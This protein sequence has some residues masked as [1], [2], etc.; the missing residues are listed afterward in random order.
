L[1]DAL[2][3]DL[4]KVKKKNFLNEIDLKNK[5][6]SKASNEAWIN[7]LTRNQS[8]I[9]E[10]FCGQYKSTISCL[11]CKIISIKY[12][13]FYILSLPIPDLEYVELKIVFINYNLA[14]G[15]FMFNI[16]IEQDAKV[17]NLRRKISKSFKIPLF[18]F[19]LCSIINNRIDR[20]FNSNIPVVKLTSTICCFQID[21]SLFNS[22]SNR[23]KILD[24]VEPSLELELNF[25]VEENITRNQ[26]SFRD[27][28]IRCDP[29]NTYYSNLDSTFTKLSDVQHNVGKSSENSNKSDIN[30][31]NNLNVDLKVFCDDNYGL[32]NDFIKVV[33]YLRAIKK[34]NIIVSKQ[35]LTFARLIYLNKNW[36]LSYIHRYIFSFLK[37]FIQD[38]QKYSGLKYI[39]DDEGFDKVYSRPDKILYTQV[40]EGSIPYVIK[41]INNNANH[42]KPCFMCKDMNCNNCLLMYN[43]NIQLLSLLQKYPIINE[44]TV[45]N[46]YMYMD[47]LQRKFCLGKKDFEIEIVFEKFFLKKDKFFSQAKTSKTVNSSFLSPQNYSLSVYDCL[48]RFIQIEDLESEN[49]WLCTNCKSLEKAK[50]NIEISKN[51]LILILQLKR[52]KNNHKVK[53]TIDFPLNNL[54]L[55]YF[56]G[57]NSK[58]DIS[59]KYDL[60]G[61]C[62]HYGSLN[63]GHYYAFCKNSLNG[64]WYKYDDAEVTEI[65][66]KDVVSPYSYVL[67]YRRKDLLNGEYDIEKL[68]N[69]PFVD[70]ENLLKNN[71]FEE[72]RTNETNNETLSNA[73]DSRKLNNT[74]VKDKF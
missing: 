9:V 53:T 30:A 28:E 56:F 73:K 18:N 35:D 42:R 12:D 25:S 6:E 70:Y 21:P 64:K 65:S 27:D 62:N 17:L 38:S 19:L 51:P 52:F 36:K 29:I 8:I 67:F 40:I 45:D 43:E 50:K 26:F 31:S 23:L 14:F 55:K 37:P 58:I 63:S 11:T 20:I 7:Y 32:N 41:I 47:M 33:L 13:P 59:T 49:A 61:V 71:Y 16:K 54:D 74:Y 10:L 48:N 15:S 4:N 72:E 24:Y 57:K 3:E 46:N 68:F 66:D 22:D 5:S 39:S 34:T 1:L 44:M 69:K 60:F 2:H